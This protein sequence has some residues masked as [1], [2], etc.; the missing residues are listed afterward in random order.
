MSFRSTVS[1]QPIAPTR[2]RSASS[3]RS[4]GYTSSPTST[5]RPRSYLGSNTSPYYSTTSLGTSSSPYSSGSSSFNYSS[6]YGGTSSYKSPYFQNGYRGSSGYATLTIPA[7]K[8]LSSYDSGHRSRAVSRNGS[9][10]S[11]DRSTSR[12]RS[13]S[14]VSNGLGSKSISLTSL[15]SEGYVVSNSG[16]AIQFMFIGYNL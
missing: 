14:V 7:T 13:Q 3:M 16:T 10:H 9:Y 8:S 11:R 12:S 6:A 2:R 5:H 1:K 15:N 4:N